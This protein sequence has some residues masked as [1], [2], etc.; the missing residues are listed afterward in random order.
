MLINLD[1]KK[2][3]YVVKTPNCTETPS[4]KCHWFFNT[5]WDNTYCHDYNKLSFNMKDITMRNWQRVDLA[6]MQKQFFDIESLYK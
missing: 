1:T 4:L 5:F 2:I 6:H 3:L